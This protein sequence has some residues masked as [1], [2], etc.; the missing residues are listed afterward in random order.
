MRALIG[1]SN[2]EYLLLFTYG[3]I[4]G[5]TNEINSSQIKSNLGFCG[6]GK[7]EVP[8][9]KP[10]GA[11]KRTNKLNSH[12][13]PSLEIEPGPH[14]MV[15]GECCHHCGFPA[16]LQ[17]ALVGIASENIVIVAGKNELKPS[18]CALL[19]HSIISLFQFILN[20]PQ[21]QLLVVY[22]HVAASPPLATSISTNSC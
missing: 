15:G 21:C 18:F 2:S 7:T 9:E 3:V 17:L 11:E 12:M 8:G 16:P 19:S 14:C 20:S 22:V 1:Y 6:E 13:T 5:G 4:I 10:F